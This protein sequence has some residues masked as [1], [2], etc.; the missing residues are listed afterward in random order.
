MR[1]RVF[2]VLLSLS[3][4]LLSACSPQ[5]PVTPAS[6]HHSDTMP[7]LSENDDGQAFLG[8]PKSTALSQARHLGLEARIIQEDEIHFPVTKDYRPR[9]LNFVILRGKVQQVSRG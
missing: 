3:L 2:I 7:S 6:A 9:R 8:L 5:P 4:I 1:L